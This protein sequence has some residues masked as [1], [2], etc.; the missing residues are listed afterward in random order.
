MAPASS[1]TQGNRGHHFEN[2]IQSELLK[3]VVNPVG[4]QKGAGAA[5][6]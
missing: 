1:Q 5:M 6:Q 3:L 4:A 2:P